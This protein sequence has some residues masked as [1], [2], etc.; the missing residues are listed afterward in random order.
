MVPKET[1]K[2]RYK[3]GHPRKFW[4]C[5]RYPECDIAVGAHPDGSPVGKPADTAT[6][7]ARTAAHKSFDAW[8]Q[9]HGYGKG[10]AYRVLA[11]GL[12]VVEPKAH[13]G[14]MNAEMCQAVV[15]FCGGNDS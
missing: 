8:K 12:R 13:M 14:Q 2:Y 11:D 9:Q 1:T 3:S 6:R 10:E 15:R 7:K 5:F 4:S